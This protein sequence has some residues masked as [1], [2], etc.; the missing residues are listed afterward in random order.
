MNLGFKEAMVRV[1]DRVV[2]QVGS[3]LGP[4]SDEHG[5]EI[6]S[7]LVVLDVVTHDAIAAAFAQPHGNVYLAADLKVTFDPPLPPPAPDPVFVALQQ[8][9]DQDKVTLADF[10]PAKAGDPPTQLD[11]F[12]ADPAPPPAAQ[13]AALKAEIRATRALIRVTRFLVRRDLV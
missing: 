3:S 9:F 10:M 12:L 2:L 7:T 13:L 4:V 1:A 11:V 8:Q 5:V 6:P